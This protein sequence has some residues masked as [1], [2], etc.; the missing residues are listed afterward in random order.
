MYTILSTPRL[1]SFS[2]V[3]EFWILAFP[4]FFDIGQFLTPFYDVLSMQILLQMLRR[5]EQR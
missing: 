4:I 3:D 2:V 5:L 1:T